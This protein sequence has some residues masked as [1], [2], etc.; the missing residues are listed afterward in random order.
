MTDSRKHAIT[1]T[2]KY[3]YSEF[4]FQPGMRKRKRSLWSAASAF[5]GGLATSGSGSGSTEAEAALKSTASASLLS[6]K[7]MLFFKDNDYYFI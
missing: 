6:T 7:S 1:N 4:R 2:G 5:V 3:M